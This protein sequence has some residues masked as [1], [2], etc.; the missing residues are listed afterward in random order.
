MPNIFVNTVYPGNSAKDIENLITRPI[1]KELGSISEIKE[2]TSS[3]EV[4][5]CRSSTTGDP[6]RFL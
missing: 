2:L 4:R 1:E 6:P 5:G 3:H